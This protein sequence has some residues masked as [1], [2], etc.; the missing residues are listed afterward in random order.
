[1]I[2]I[3]LKMIFICSLI[4]IPLRIKSIFER[5]I[6]CGV[7]NKRQ[8]VKKTRPPQYSIDILRLLSAGVIENDIAEGLYADVKTAVID[9]EI[10]GM[11]R[12]L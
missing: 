6:V 2:I 9:N 12:G 10:R 1:M 11:M 7:R 3:L 8:F 4:I 5:S